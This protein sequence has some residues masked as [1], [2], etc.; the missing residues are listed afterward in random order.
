MSASRIVELGNSIQLNT[1]KLDI[2]YS[3]KGIPTPSFGIE[4]PLEINLPDEFKACRQAVI[5]AT[6]ELHMLML[7]PVHTVGWLR[8]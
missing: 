5:E 1:L 4:T 7:G 8:V 3:S 2:Y 6:D